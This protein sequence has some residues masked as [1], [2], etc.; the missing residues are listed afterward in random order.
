MKNFINACR[1][2]GE[3]ICLIQ[4]SQIRHFLLISVFLPII[5]DVDIGISCHKNKTF[6][7]WKPNS[8]WRIPFCS[9]RLKY[10]GQKTL[11]RDISAWPDLCSGISSEMKCLWNMFITSTWESK[12]QLSGMASLKG[13]QTAEDAPPDEAVGVPPVH[14]RGAGPDISFQP[15]PFNGSMIPSWGV[16]LVLMK[17]SLVTACYPILWLRAT[18]TMHKLFSCHHSHPHFFTLPLRTAWGGQNDSSCLVTGNHAGPHAR[19]PQPS[20][21]CV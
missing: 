11:T 1:E 7:C 12:T 17:I 9:E 13:Y 16:P 21:C 5:L 3:N 15:K 18:H 10:F 19:K 2:T 8:N 6:L 14:C 4:A 20:S